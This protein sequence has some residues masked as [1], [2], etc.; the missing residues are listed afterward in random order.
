MKEYFRKVRTIDVNTYKRFRALFYEA[1]PQL[2]A[3][4]SAVKNLWEKI[5]CTGKKKEIIKE[6]IDYNNRKAKHEK[7]DKINMTCYKYLKSKV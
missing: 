3:E 6:L 5:N 4:H 2:K 1:S 7:V